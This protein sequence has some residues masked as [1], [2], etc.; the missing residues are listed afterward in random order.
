MPK[1]KSE[2]SISEDNSNDSIFM[3][4][5]RPRK[6][7]SMQMNVSSEIKDLEVQLRSSLR[8]LFKDL[9]PEEEIT[10]EFELDVKSVPCKTEELR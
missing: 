7:Q 3:N 9:R 10:I 6:K 1:S 5:C 4:I 2:R 8:T